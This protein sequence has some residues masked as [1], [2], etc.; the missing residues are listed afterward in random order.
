MG[1][2]C[3]LF[4]SRKDGAQIIILKKYEPEKEAYELVFTFEQEGAL[5]EA[6]AMGL[7]EETAERVFS[8]FNQDKAERVLRDPLGFFINSQAKQSKLK[9]R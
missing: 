6:K 3:K 7:T 2:F 8:G 5:I 9:P 1:K 4:E